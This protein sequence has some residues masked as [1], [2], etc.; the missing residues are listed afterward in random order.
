MRWRY[1]GVSIRGDDLNV[2]L[3]FFFFLALLE[4][5]RMTIPTWLWSYPPCFCSVLLVTFW[6]LEKFSATTNEKDDKFLSQI[7]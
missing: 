6:L 3:H 5:M 2:G 1:Y 4:K 7:I